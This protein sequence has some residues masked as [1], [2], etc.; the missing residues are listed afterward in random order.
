M[1]FLL[2]MSLEYNLL[3]NDW[4]SPGLKYCFCYVC[5]Y[6]GTKSKVVLEAHIHY[7]SIHM[8]VESATSE[9]ERLKHYSEHQNSLGKTLP[10]SRFVKC[11]L[12]CLLADRSLF[13][14]IISSSSVYPV[15]SFAKAWCWEHEVIIKA[16]CIRKREGMALLP[17]ELAIS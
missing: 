11:C 17:P 3:W 14:N 16:S 1:V 9:K 2:V 13:V 10:D 8:A 12:R 5:M 4:Q 15:K 6:A 7:N